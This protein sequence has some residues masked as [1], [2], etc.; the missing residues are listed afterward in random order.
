MYTLSSEMRGV[1]GGFS[2]DV[3]IFPGSCG[4]ATEKSLI[5]NL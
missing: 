3:K 2:C 4:A 5:P 1:N